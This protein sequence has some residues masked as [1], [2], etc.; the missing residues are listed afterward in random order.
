MGTDRAM[1]ALL[2]QS[3]R[4]PGTPSL[5]PRRRVR[6]PMSLRVRD[7]RPEDAEELHALLHAAY[8][9]RGEER[10]LTDT[11]ERVRADINEGLVLVAEDDAGRLVASV[12]LRRIVNVRRLA[13]APHRKGE[14]LGARM[15]AAA[16]E[17]ARAEGFAWSML[18]TIPTHPW[19]PD[20]YR[21][22]GYEERCVERFPDGN[23]WVQFR[24]RLR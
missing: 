5:K 2:L 18:D 1:G 16:E 8:R 11:V 21:K 22:S 15:L 6:A 3:G 20:F 14:R 23:D 9:D 7:A 17:R 12:M 24:K 4:A 19:L 13:V 10:P